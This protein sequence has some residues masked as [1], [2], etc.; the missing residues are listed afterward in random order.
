[1]ILTVY[2]ICWD[3]YLL[4]INIIIVSFFFSLLDKI[5]LNCWSILSFFQIFSD[6]LSLWVWI[7]SIS[8]K[9][10]FKNYRIWY[11]VINDWFSKLWQ[12][13]E[14]WFGFLYFLTFG[15]PLIVH[16]RHL[17]EEWY[18]QYFSIELTRE[19]TLGAI[20][21]IW[22]PHL[23]PA[24]FVAFRVCCCCKRSQIASE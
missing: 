23:R 24:P 14:N 9:F 17:C 2:Y 22:L 21:Y 8:L 7:Y 19:A 15:H 10:N 12:L 13:S 4:V 20:R 5:Y 6:L 1:M 11:G 3:K 18:G 16:N